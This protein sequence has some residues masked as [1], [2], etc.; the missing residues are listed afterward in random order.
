MLPSFDQPNQCLAPRGDAASLVLEAERVALAG[1]EDCK[2]QAAQLVATSRLH[3]ELAYQR[4]EA[5]IK[6]LHE[7]MAAAAQRCQMQISS[8]M[9]ALANNVGTDGSIP[10]TLDDAIARVTAELA[11]IPESS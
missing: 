8:E 5:R 1:V 7:Q 2:H 11:G 3:A 9:A 10:A 4:T 6:R